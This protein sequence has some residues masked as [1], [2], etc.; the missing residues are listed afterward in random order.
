MGPDADL[1][2]QLEPI[3]VKNGV[4][5]VMTGHEH[6]Y[7]RIKPQKGVNYFIL[8]NSGQLRPHDLTPS[9]DTLKGWDTDQAFML[10]EIAGDELYFQT[11]ARDGTT[12]D[13]GMI[14][15]QLAAA[16]ATSK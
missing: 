8:G 15:R 6:V 7:E 9:A 10:V 13:A 16:A 11:I 2:S 3:F 14:P 12:V 4:N 5:V 1:K